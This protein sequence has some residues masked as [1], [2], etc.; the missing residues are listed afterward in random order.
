[1]QAQLTTQMSKK[2]AQYSNLDIAKFIC[3]LLVV[4]IH[5]QPISPDDGLWYFYVQH[6]ITRVAVP[7]F[8]AISG[9][10]FFSKLIYENGKIKHCREN[11]KRLWNCIKKN[12]TIYLV[13]SAIYIVARL[14]Q[15]YASGWWG[16]HAVK[17]TMV[18]TIFVGTKYHLWYLLATIYAF[19]LLYLL[20]A[21]VSIKRVWSIL[22][23]LWA[24]ECLTYSYQWALPVQIPFISFIHS[25]MSIIPATLFCAIPLLAIG[26]ITAEKSTKTKWNFTIAGIGQFLC[27]TEATLLYL[28]SPNQ[29]QVSY[30]ICTPVFAYAAL[31]WLIESNQC[32][33]PAKT[34]FALRNM[35][36][37]IYCLHPLVIDLFDMMH[38][39]HGLLQWLLVTV[40]VVG[41]SRLWVKRKAHLK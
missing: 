3:A 39:T 12:G 33:I 30:L 28:Y 36:L 25:R 35:S 21:V 10:L 13:W 9:Y 23:V 24:G 4:V 11:T 5:T 6:V 22:I 16:W 15:W 7:L 41:A 40:I 29:T 17:D 18:S 32:S 27:A 37:T 26:A 8:F 34:A 19:P 2:S 38:L 20:L 1:M 14:P 31:N